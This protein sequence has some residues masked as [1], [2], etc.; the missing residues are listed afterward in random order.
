M[1]LLNLT[2]RWSPLR[3]H[4]EQSRLFHHPARFKV[5]P[6][7]RR[8]GKT[9]LAKRKLVLSLWDCF[10]SPKPWPDARY[11]A[12]AP[13]RDQAKRLW[14][15]DLKRLTPRAWRSQVV[16]T[17]L[18]IK[19]LWGA[20][21]WV[22]GLDKPQ[23]MEGVGWDGG[24]IDE[25]ADCRPG[26]FEANIRPALAD[27]NGWLWMIGVPDAEGPAQV[28]YEK[29][30]NLARSG[31]D[32][33][34]AGFTW[35]SGDILPAD[36]VESARRRMDPR[37]FEQEYLGRFV[38]AQ[39]RAFPDFDIATHV[40]PCPYDPALPVCWSLDFNINPMCSGVVQ[41]HRGEVRVIAEM[42][43]PQTDTQS[44]CEEFAD[45][46]KRNNWNLSRL[47]IYG[48]STGYARDSTSGTT[49]W[50][51]ICRQFP[52]AMMKVPRKAPRIRDTVNSVNAKLRAADGTVSLWIDPSCG[53]L[54][55][56]LQDAVIS[57]DMEEQHAVAWLRYFVHREF[58]LTRT[59]TI[60]GR[61]A[62]AND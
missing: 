16:E 23:R 10:V 44:A 36:E 29:L 43:L 59:P 12:A 54:I 20:E 2:P 3:H 32:P 18:C 9:E 47:T 50:A 6:A 37:I 11:F 28:E 22:I 58:P 31:L 17:D 62:F 34:W 24:V 49:D 60:E 30:W 14:W 39:G 46:A 55:G 42:A 19:T 5:V 52:N 40:R 53:R 41:H 13:T 27:R 51:I 1:P 38:L 61:I 33:E 15:E 48:D 7:G 8:S 25:Y 56:D 4:L 45:R 26:S 35:A 57:N 21:L